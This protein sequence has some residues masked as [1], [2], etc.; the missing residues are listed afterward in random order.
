MLGYAMQN[1]YIKGYTNDSIQIRFSLDEHDETYSFYFKDSI[2]TRLYF[3]YYGGSKRYFYFNPYK[4]T[5]GKLEIK[6]SLD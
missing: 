5:K 2:D 4:A 1:T 6:Y 3:D